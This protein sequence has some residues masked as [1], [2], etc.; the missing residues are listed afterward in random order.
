MPKISVIVPVYRAES[1]LELCTDSILGQSFRISSCFWWRTAPDGSGALCDAVAA[2]DGRVRVFH[3]ENGGVSSARNLGLREAAGDYIAFVDA[4]DWL[5][6]D[7]LE[8]LSGALAGAGADT[9]G[10]AHYNVLP[11]GQKWAEPGALSAGVYDGDA[12]RTGI[13]NRLLGSVSAG[14]APF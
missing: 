10:C 3:K 2:R 4:D 7:A 1:F 12:L 9:A 11:S 14:R 5:L 6:P 13:V 8:I